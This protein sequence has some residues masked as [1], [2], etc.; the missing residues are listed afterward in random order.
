MKK[1]ICEHCEYWTKDKR[2]PAHKCYTHK[3]PAYKRDSGQKLII[4]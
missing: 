3:C 2:D 4:L 1:P